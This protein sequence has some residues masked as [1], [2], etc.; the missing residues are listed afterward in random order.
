[1]KYTPRR[2]SKRWLDGDCPDGVLAIF[3]NK[4]F[5]DCYIVIYKEIYGGE[6]YIGGYMWGRGMSSNPFHPQ[7]V[8]MSFELRPYEVAKYRYVNR[9]RAHKWSELPKD[10]QECVIRDL[11]GEVK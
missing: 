2:A 10:V 6:G 7:G 3:Y 4:N 1:M 11:K 5:S 9:H 8:G